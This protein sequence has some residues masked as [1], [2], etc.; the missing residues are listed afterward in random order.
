MNAGALPLLPPKGTLKFVD[1]RLVLLVNVTLLISS[2]LR[3]ARCYFLLRPIAPIPLRRI[4]SIAC[5]ATGLLTFLPFRLGEV[6]KP[7]LLRQKGR[8]SALAVTG[9]VGAER[10]TDGL[11]LSG[12]LCLGLFFAKPIEPLP[13]RIGNIPVPT[14][15]IPHVATVS[16]LVFG[17]GFC[18]M[19]A[20]FLWR[21]LARRV[22]EKSI[23]LVSQRFATKLADVLERFSDGLKFLSDVRHATPFLLFTLVAFYAHLWALQLLAL[24]VG[25]P[26]LGTA[27]AAVILGVLGLGFAVPNAPGFFGAIQL[28][29]Y[30][31]MAVYLPPHTVVHE[32][33]TFTFIFYCG[34]VVQVVLLTIAGLVGEWRFSRE[35]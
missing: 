25:L 8:L 19:V 31:G 2:L 17:G 32:G 18:V 14:A 20:F 16:L 7:A 33:A 15:L 28:A 23:G 3:M 6:T 26:P 24:A 4:M 5:V 22:V 12:M 10:I 30:A 11:T 29:L 9:T 34:Y 13:T 35:T 21:T 1:Y 27:Q